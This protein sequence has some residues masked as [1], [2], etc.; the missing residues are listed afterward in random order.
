MI[1]IKA[2]NKVLVRSML[3]IAKNAK[4]YQG[5]DTQTKV[6]EAISDMT[7]DYK[8]TT[9]GNVSAGNDIDLDNVTVIK[10]NE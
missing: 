8:E 7:E 3:K 9:A 6:D 1:D 4:A 10:E 2:L 5:A